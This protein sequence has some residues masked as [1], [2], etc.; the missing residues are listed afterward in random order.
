[1]TRAVI[2]LLLTTFGFYSSHSYAFRCNLKNVI[3]ASRMHGF[4]YCEK[5]RTN[6]LERKLRATRIEEQDGQTVNSPT[7]VEPLSSI[8]P[9]DEFEMSRS[10]LFLAKAGT[11]GAATGLSVILFKS[12][13]AIVLTLFYENLADALPKPVFYWPFILCK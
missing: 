1:M 8:L 11:V 6:S 5:Y 9:D 10:A 3:S 13:I 12:S 2:L 7:V 4:C